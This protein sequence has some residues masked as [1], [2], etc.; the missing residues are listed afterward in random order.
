MER[1][2]GRRERGKAEKQTRICRAARDLFAENGYEAVTTQQVAD[3]ADVA[4]GTLF[5]YASSKAEL[6]LMV[7]NE[8]FAAAVAQG[9]V[10]SAGVADPVQR[11]LALIG[12]V[13]HSGRDH[14]ENL[15]AYQ[16]DLLFGP[17]DAPFRVAGLQIVT[18]LEELIAA[19]LTGGDPA[20]EDATA[21]GRAVFAVLHL[22]IAGP[23]VRASEPGVASGAL[24]RQVELIVAGYQARR[25]QQQSTKG[26][27]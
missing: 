21:A 14:D 8:A 25:P 5:R 12:P 13:I 23:V 22:E 1:V 2:S 24:R 26:R 20:D 18:R 16:R 9:E 15:V 7:Y 27:A 19:C 17:P 3:R 10:E 11:V 6:L 4:I